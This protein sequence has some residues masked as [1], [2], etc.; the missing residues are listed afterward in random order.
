MLQSVTHGSQSRSTALGD[1]RPQRT[2]VQRFLTVA[3]L[4]RRPRDR[5]SDFVLARCGWK[6]RTSVATMVAKLPPRCVPGPWL[7]TAGWTSALSVAQR[8][9][10]TLVRAAA[11]PRHRTRDKSCA[12]SGYF[13]CF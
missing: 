2:A 4:M 6:L 1:S 10:A 7:D 12:H 9:R 3:V 13:H 11:S 5:G 8:R